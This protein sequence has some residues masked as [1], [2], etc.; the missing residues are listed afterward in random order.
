MKKLVVTSIILFLLIEISKSPGDTP[1]SVAMDLFLTADILCFMYHLK[2][3]LY[4]ILDKS[5]NI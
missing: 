4:V 2:N 1:S 5:I 3:I